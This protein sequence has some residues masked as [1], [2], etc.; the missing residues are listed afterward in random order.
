M[1]APGAALSYLA[2]TSISGCQFCSQ[3]NSVRDSSL[4]Q[5]QVRFRG[6]L[7]LIDT[8]NRHMQLRF[9]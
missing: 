4:L 6:F 9:Y 3:N 8:R 5:T 7:Q 1:S 2:K